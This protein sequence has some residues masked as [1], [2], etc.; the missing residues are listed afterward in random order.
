MK[1]KLF[2]ILA[3]GT[4]ILAILACNLPGGQVSSQP[5]LAATITAQAVAL[6][7]LSATPAPVQTVSTPLPNDTPQPADTALP[8]APSKPKNSEARGR[9]QPSQFSGMTPPLTKTE[10]GTI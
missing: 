1:N 4:M 6:Q 3:S 10:S 9:P 8:A 2:P 7:A 5:D